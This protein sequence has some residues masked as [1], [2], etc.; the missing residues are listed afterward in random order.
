MK[1]LCSNI[2]ITTD[3]HH[4]FFSISLTF[5][6]PS[7]FLTKLLVSVV[8][9]A[10]TFLTNSSYSFFFTSSSYSVFLKTL[11]FTTSLSL[12]KPAGI[13]TN[14]STSN[15]LLYFSNWLN[16]LVYF[17]MYQYLIYLHQILSLLNQ[18]FYQNPMHRYLLHF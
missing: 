16:Y 9:I 13:G 1:F 14:L 5:V 15:Y 2:L 8:W 6:L 7:V 4:D 18:S 3:H 17:A 10:L 11:L 12:H